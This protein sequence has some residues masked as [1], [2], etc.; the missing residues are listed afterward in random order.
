MIGNSLTRRKAQ[1][2]VPVPIKNKAIC[3]KAV[4]NMNELRVFNN[5]EL[6]M[7]VRTVIND[8]GSISINAEDAAIGF[9]WTT[10]AK[11][12]NE[13]VRWARV[14]EYCEQLGFPNKLG[15]DD[16]IPESLYYMLGFKAGNER[17][18][19]YQR[20][21]AIDVIPQLRKTGS[22]SIHNKSD[23]EKGLT[24]VKFIADDMRVNDASR[25]LMYENLCKDYNI[26]TG[27]LP[28][29]EHNG[30]R[31]MKAAKHLLEENGCS[32]SSKKLNILL[33]EQGYLE[34]KSRPSS[35]GNEIR[36]Y[37]SLTEKGLKYGENAVNPHNQRET[38]P[39]YYTDKFMELYNIVT[40]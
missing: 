16:Y 8:D 13:V 12:G 40:V 15:K 33:M 27:F 23:I 10:V 34:E 39:L 3:G 21:L 11:S 9:G 35:K 14:N 5:S 24:A 20:W 22:Y 28:K 25:I 6:G 30:S 26:P 36:K 37:K 4:D 38:Q 29:Y 19:K 1:A 18:L 17:A 7:T 2:L 32:I 31:E